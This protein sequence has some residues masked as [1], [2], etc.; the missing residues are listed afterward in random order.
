MFE[1]IKVWLFNKKKSE[2]ITR[3]I[4]IFTVVISA[5]GLTAGMVEKENRNFDSIGGVFVLLLVGLL[6]YFSHD[7][8]FKNK[9]TYFTTLLTYIFLYSFFYIMLDT[10]ALATIIGLIAILIILQPIF[11]LIISIKE[12]K[13]MKEKAR[14]KVKI[15]MY[16]VISSALVLIFLST[17]LDSFK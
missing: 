15:T 6:L 10:N 17:V 3:K 7:R 1:K 12:V 2:I 4:G 11:N 16:L 13:F 5:I 8:I 14:V 9:L